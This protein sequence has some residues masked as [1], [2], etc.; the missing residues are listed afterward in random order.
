MDEK[1]KKQIELHSA[2]ATVRHKSPF[3]ELESYKNE[4]KLD[5]KF[6]NKWVIPFYFELNNQSDNW[7]ERMIRVKSELTEDV[8]LKNLGDFNWRTRSTGSYFASIKQAHHLEDIIG[9]H[10]LKSEVC[11]AG[12]EYAKTIASFNTSKSPNYLKKYLEYYLKKPELYFD[13]DSVMVALKYLDEINYTNHV[14]EHMEDWN[15]MLKWRNN[16]TYRNLQNLKKTVPE[17]SN[18]ID[19]ELNIIGPIDNSIDTEYFK[20]YIDTLKTIIEN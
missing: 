6:I 12:A 14:D 9:T 2:G 5:Q 1:T 18:E 20:G 16:Y 15:N 8:I 11:Y 13:Q 19:K 3:S 4:E 7:I 17:K 10:L